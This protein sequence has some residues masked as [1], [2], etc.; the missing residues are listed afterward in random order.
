MQVV[1]NKKDKEQ[2][3]IKLYQ[4]G[5]PIREI[6]RQAHLSFGSIGKIIRTINN[7]SDDDTNSDN[8]SSKTKSTKA[9]YL[10]KSGKKPIDVA[11]ELDLSSMQVEEL[12]QEF[13]ALNQLHELMFVYDEIK[14]YLSS[15][16]KLFNLLKRNKM[17]GEE[18]ISKF[19][20]YADHDLPTLENKIQNLTG[21]VI[22]LEWKKKDLKDTI[23]LWNAQLS[24]LGQTITQYQNAIDNKKQQ[25]MRMD[26][27]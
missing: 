19:I 12:Q 1:L 26:I 8:Y 27:Y 6:A 25:L 16:T 17:L 14:N 22:D 10:F 18:H 11:I 23:T 15:F 20:K 7:S 13:W 3:V 9:L 5:R 21:D 4:E 2:L 24:D